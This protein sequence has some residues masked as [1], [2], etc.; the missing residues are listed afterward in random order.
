MLTFLQ[1]IFHKL[2]PKL[3]LMDLN[4]IRKFMD[5]ISMVIMVLL[6]REGFLILRKNNLL[7]YTLQFKLKSTPTTSSLEDTTQLF[8][9][10]SSKT[11]VGFVKGGMNNNSNSQYLTNSRKIKNKFTCISTFNYSLQDSLI[12]NKKM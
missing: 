3:L 2:D 10:K 6:I 4:P 9:L 11:Y 5:F 8:H 7:L 12:F 1:I